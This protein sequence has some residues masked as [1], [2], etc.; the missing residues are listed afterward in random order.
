MRRK[1][2]WRWR[3]CHTRTLTPPRAGRDANFLKGWVGK[4]ARGWEREGFHRFRVWVYHT[5]VLIKIRDKPSY[6]GKKKEGV[7]NPITPDERYSNSKMGLGTSAEVR[8]GIVKPSGG[9]TYHEWPQGGDGTTSP[10]PWSLPS[11]LNKKHYKKGLFSLGSS[12]ISIEI[13]STLDKSYI[14]C[15]STFEKQ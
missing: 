11:Y 5:H 8:S 1:T 12:Q 14:S 4:R 7:L 6:K 13:I 9:D 2:S 10:T 15:V 3:N